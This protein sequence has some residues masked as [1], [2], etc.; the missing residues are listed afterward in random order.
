VIC[1]QI[2]AAKK[3]LA[4][5]HDYRTGSVLKI[6]LSLEDFMN[7]S[8][9]PK[10]P[11]P[12][13]PGLAAQHCLALSIPVKL[14]TP[15]ALR[16]SGN[17][18][19]IAEAFS[20][21]AKPTGVAGGP[22]LNISPGGGLVHFADA[23]LMEGNRVLVVAIYD[24][25]WDPYIDAFLNN[26]ALVYLR[27]GLHGAESG[28]VPGAGGRFLAPVPDRS[29]GH[30]QGDVPGV[31]ARPDEERPSPAVHHHQRKRL[32]VSAEHRSA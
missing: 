22:A 31:P 24:G 27:R 5:R 20:G 19:K 28:A 13:D 11:S 16:D 25:E 15:A 1:G 23:V 12:I 32:S 29:A 18:K 21:G 6:I 17:I 9:P 14:P 7:V 26:E 3:R 2:S 30:A 10:N 8:A 4:K